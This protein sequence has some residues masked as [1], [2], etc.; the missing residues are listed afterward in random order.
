MFYTVKVSHNK[1]HTQKENNLAMIK[2]CQKDMM[3]NKRAPLSK[4]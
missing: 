1:E 2:A 4:N 3:A